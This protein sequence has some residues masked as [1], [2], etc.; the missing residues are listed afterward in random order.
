MR[1]DSAFTLSGFKVDETK[2]I[3]S[4]KQNIKEEKDNRPD[5]EITEYQYL[6]KADE[7]LLNKA[8]EKANKTLDNHNKII[9]R[10]I[11][12][13]TKAIMFKIEDTET[14]EIIREFPPEKIQDMIAKM[15]EMVGLFVDKR[16]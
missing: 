13:K 9:K 15:W 6:S 16:S 2:S 1:V 4:S 12:E 8:I 10:E 5:E 3:E 14:G 11:H 7:N